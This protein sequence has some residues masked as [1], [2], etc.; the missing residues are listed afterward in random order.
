MGGKTSKGQRQRRRKILEAIHP[1]PAH[2]SQPDP[3]QL[4]KLPV[5]YQEIN[6]YYEGFKEAKPFIMRKET[7]TRIEAITGRPLICYVAKTSHVAPILPIAIDDSDLIGFT[8]LAHSVTGKEVDVFIE[9]N[10]GSAEAAERIVRLLR[11]R[12]DSIRFIVPSNAYSAAT[13]VCFSANSVVMSPTAT[14]GPIDPQIN[15]IPARAI[16]RAFKALEQRLAEEGPRALTAY[17]PLISKYDLHLFEICK[18]AE[19]LSKELAVRWLSE[20]MLQCEK[21]DPR[22][23]TAVDYFS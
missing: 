13:L 14:F 1:I 4:D 9:S 20:Y 18:S 6:D 10:G 21:D 5:S 19:D 12:F 7:F 3:S 2:P 23:V 8:D 17:V 11:A 22:I 16:L 15:G